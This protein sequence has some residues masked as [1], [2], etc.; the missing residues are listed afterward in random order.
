MDLRE[1]AASVLSMVRYVWALVRER[2]RRDWRGPV[3]VRVS[4]NDRPGYA[5]DPKAGAWYA[6]ARWKPEPSYATGRLAC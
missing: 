3:W 4:D 6:P 1:R 5:Y 2:G